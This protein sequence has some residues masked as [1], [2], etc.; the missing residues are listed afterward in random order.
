MTVLLTQE[1]E[2][3][4]IAEMKKG[5]RERVCAANN[6]AFSVFAASKTANVAPKCRFF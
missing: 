2:T 6:A 3:L 5:A 1:S 4:K